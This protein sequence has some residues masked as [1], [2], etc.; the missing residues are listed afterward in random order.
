MNEEKYIDE[1][2]IQRKKI[3]FN[4]ISR[5]NKELET[6]STQDIIDIVACYRRYINTVSEKIM[7][8]K[9]LQDE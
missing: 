6:G 5:I 2:A 7:I 3:E 9:D 4:F 8:M 1:M